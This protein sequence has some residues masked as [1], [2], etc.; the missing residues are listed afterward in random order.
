MFKKIFNLI[1]Q[2]KKNPAP[3]NSAIHISAEDQ[4]IEAS[5]MRAIEK[6][7]SVNQENFSCEVKNSSFLV[8]MKGESMDQALRRHHNSAGNSGFIETFNHPE[9]NKNLPGVTK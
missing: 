6:I 4:L 2:I 1:F 5:A 8:V 7:K 3:N 9:I